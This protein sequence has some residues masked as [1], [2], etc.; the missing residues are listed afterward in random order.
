MRRFVLV[1][2]VALA[3]LA[4][5]AGPALADTCANV[6]RAAPTGPVTGPLIKGNWVWLPSVGAPIDAW[7]FAPPGA[8]D[9]VLFGFPG[10]N[11]NYT[12][13]KTDSLLGVSANC[14]PGANPNRQTT[15]GIQS[16][17]GLR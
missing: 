12:N 16:G 17:C 7:G 14:P 11:G 15:N 13:G 1:A 4:V 9:S 10:A 5:T 6:S 8:L 3:S 2:S